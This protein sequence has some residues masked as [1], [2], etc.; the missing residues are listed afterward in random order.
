LGE[1][2]K[3]RDARDEKQDVVEIEHRGKMSG[4]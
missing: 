2:E 3:R 4:R 1:Q